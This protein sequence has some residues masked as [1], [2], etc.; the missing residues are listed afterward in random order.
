MGFLEKI[1]NKKKNNDKLKQ[2]LQ[3]KNTDS[4]GNVAM[5]L[6][7]SGVIT[8]PKDDNH[9]TFGEKLDKLVDGDLPWGWE[10]A[11]QSFIKPRDNKLYDLSIRAS[12]AENIDEEIKLLKEF[13]A[14]FKEYENECSEKGECYQKYFLDMHIKQPNRPRY[15]WLKDKKERLKYLEENYKK[16][17][18]ESKIKEEQCKDLSEKLI[19]II[20]NNPGILQSDIYKQFHE[21]IRD[22]VSSKL[23]FWNKSG[24]IIREKSGRTYKIYYNK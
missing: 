24:K 20:S 10:N 12:K 5:K 7:K 18:D 17:K 16:I 13:I 11:K 6:A 19:Q 9:N 1:F 8:V 23:Y 3:I 22:E 2:D 4:L 15:S 21:V 14:F